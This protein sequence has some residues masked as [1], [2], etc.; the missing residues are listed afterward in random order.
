MFSRN[1]DTIAQEWSGFTRNLSLRRAPAYQCVS[2][3]INSTS[4]FEGTL[5]GRRIEEIN[6]AARF[7][8]N[9]LPT[10]LAGA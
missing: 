2:S 6:E 8:A 9:R 1:F 10:D 5:P 3:S 4:N 7:F